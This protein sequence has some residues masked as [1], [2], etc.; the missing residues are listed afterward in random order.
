MKVEVI[1][2][3]QNTTKIKRNNYLEDNNKTVK[4]KTI[5]RMRNEKSG[6][7]KDQL[8][9]REDRQIDLKERSL[10]LEKYD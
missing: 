10:K 1:D 4:K 6:F 8:M 2:Q 3:N 7:E 5:G 9:N